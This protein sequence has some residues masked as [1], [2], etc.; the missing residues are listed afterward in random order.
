MGILLNEYVLKNVT[1]FCFTSSLCIADINECQTLS[2]CSSDA[3]CADV[4]GSFTCTCNV[5]FT[6][7]GITCS[8]KAL[9]FHICFCDIIFLEVHL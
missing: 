8:G 9:F 5:G 7:N 2:P 1:G 3:T 4:P 6:G